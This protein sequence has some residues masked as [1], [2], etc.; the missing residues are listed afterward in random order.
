M[1][2]AL[3]A[4]DATVGSEE[5]RALLRELVQNR[6]QEHLV[7]GWLRGERDADKRRLLGQLGALDLALPG[8]GVAGYVDRAR[9]LLRASRLGESR[10]LGYTPSVPSGHELELGSD[11]FARY[12]A[13]GAEAVG[14]CAFVLVAGG[15]GERLGY[16]GAKLCLPTELLTRT[17][18]LGL[19]AQLLRAL[20]S[21]APEGAA[22]LPLVIM[23]SDDTHAPTAALLDDNAYFGLARDQ[24]HLLKQEK[25]PC[26]ADG[27]ARLASAP[28][29]RYALLTK[30]H[31]HGD[32][33]SLLHA[34]G[35]AARLLPLRLRHSR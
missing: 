29:D 26:L 19:Y 11:A 3:D 28:G 7:A 31:G 12:E 15:L 35:L 30:P 27:D 1:A 13:A 18:Y 4:L 24:V 2:A 34:S 16:S 25:V 17:T 5:E 9:A 23:T 8:G 32:V 22:P 14:G 33:H 20:H 21:L 10:L 6:G